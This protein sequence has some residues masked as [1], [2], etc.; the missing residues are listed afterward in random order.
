[1]PVRTIPGVFSTVHRSPAPEIPSSSMVV[2]VR[3]HHPHTPGVSLVTARQI[4]N[5]NALH[6][7]AGHEV[8]ST[9]YGAPSPG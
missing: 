9:A 1:M 7:G 3:F 4:G 5:D 6:V 8:R 2:Y